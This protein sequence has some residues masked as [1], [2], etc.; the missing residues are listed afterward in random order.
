[1][2]EGQGT[3][4]ISERTAEQI[5][6][7]YVKSF[8]FIIRVTDLLLTLHLKYAEETLHNTRLYTSSIM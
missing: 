2:A 8:M 3:N 5:L 7:Y 6:N 1:M 4:G